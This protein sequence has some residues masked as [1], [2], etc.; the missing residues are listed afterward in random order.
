MPFF[1][2]DF[3][4]LGRTKSGQDRH[5]TGDGVIIPMLYVL[6]YFIAQF[7][8]FQR[9]GNMDIFCTANNNGFD[10]LVSHHGTDTASTGTGSSLLNGCIKDPVFTG[11]SNGGNLGFGLFQFF[12]NGLC[13]FKR[14]LT[15]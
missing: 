6:H 7:H 1:I 12:S 11:L 4:F 8:I 5:D 9:L 14:S 10:S 13:S 2:M 15:L 3:H